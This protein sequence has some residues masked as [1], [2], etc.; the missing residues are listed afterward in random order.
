ML[1]TLIVLAL[2]LGGLLNFTAIAT[3]QTPEAT[4]E[5]TSEKSC[6]TELEGVIFDPMI[7]KY[8]RIDQLTCQGRWEEAATLAH[9]MVLEQRD[10]EG[11][12][13]CGVALSLGEVQATQQEWQS[14]FETYYFALSNP[15][16]LDGSEY[17]VFGH[18]LVIYNQM[19]AAL[20]AFQKFG[21]YLGHQDPQANH[22]QAFV[23]TRLGDSLFTLNRLD[24]AQTAYNTA[25]TLNAEEPFAYQGLGLVFMAKEQWTEA[26]AAFEKTLELHP[27]LTETQQYLREAQQQLNKKSSPV[28][29]L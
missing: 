8:Q 14:A 17:D 2:T 22:T 29:G 28:E 23:Y 10:S 15:V 13:L 3:A 25:L 4:P 24:E 7:R 27:T 9:D 20:I 16:I 26:I 5:V 6:E 18:Q 21:A 19:D 11:C 1:Q 12:P